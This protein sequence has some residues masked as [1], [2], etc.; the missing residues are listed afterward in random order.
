MP[1]LINS[2]ILLLIYLAWHTV[3]YDP[4][5]IPFIVSGGERYHNVGNQFSVYDE[6]SGM[7]ENYDGNLDNPTLTGLPLYRTINDSQDELGIPAANSDIKQQQRPNPIKDAIYEGHFSFWNY[8]A[9][10]IDYID[11]N[12]TPPHERNPNVSMGMPPA[13]GIKGVPSMPSKTSNKILNTTKES[14]LKKS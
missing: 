3:A 6:K 12:N 11:H 1:L 4:V 2:K 5:D 10:S 8:I 9:Y 7:W 14:S 13:V